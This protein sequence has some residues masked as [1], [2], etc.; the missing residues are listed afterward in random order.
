[1]ERTTPRASGVNRY[2]LT[3]ES[4]ATGKN[5]IDVVTVAASTAARLRC[6]LFRRCPRR[7][8][9]LHI[10]EDVFQNHHAVVDEPRE[11]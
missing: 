2:L 5:T 11:G 1:M 3:P 7:L 10:A 6:P 8:A 9:Q 4:E